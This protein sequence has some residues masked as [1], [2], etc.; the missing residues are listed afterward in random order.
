MIKVLIVI[1]LTLMRVARDENVDL[2]L[3]L[4]SF[5]RLRVLPRNQLVPMNHSYSETSNIKH[6]SIRKIAAIAVTSYRVNVGRER[7]K[8]LVLIAD[9]SRD[10][11]VLH[12]VGY[13]HALELR[14]NLAGAIRNVRISQHQNKLSKVCHLGLG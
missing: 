4:D 10:Y 2:Q 9:V 12:L 11:D 5:H 3:A 13:Q 6:F 8:G 1:D 14:R 7:R